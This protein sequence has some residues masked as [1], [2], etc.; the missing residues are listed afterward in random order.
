MTYFIESTIIK[1]PIIIEIYYGLFDICIDIT[2]LKLII[3]MDILWQSERMELNLLYMTIV[4][5]VSVYC[6]QEGYILLDCNWVLLALLMWL[7]N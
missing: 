1:V 7:L 2:S 5:S 6:H 4:L 3:S